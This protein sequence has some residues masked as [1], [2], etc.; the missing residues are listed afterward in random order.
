ML[1]VV[2]Q[3]SRLMEAR[4]WEKGTEQTTRWLLKLL[5]PEPSVTSAHAASAKASRTPI[6]NFRG[7]GSVVWHGPPEEMQKY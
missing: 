6:R 7:E 5:P 4:S 2:T 1:P 3:G